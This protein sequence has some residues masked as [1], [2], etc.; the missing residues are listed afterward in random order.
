[1]AKIIGCD[2]HPRFQQIAFFGA[3][4]GEFGERRLSHPE[5]AERFYRSLAGQ[6]VR[7]GVEATGNFGC[8]SG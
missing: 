6:A 3:G 8:F 5:E 2:F 1:M 4:D 7:I